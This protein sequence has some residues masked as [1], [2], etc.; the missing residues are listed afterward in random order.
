MVKHDRLSLYELHLNL[1]IGLR[2][3]GAVFTYDYSV[4]CSKEP[5]L[6]IALL[7]GVLKKIRT[8]TASHG[9]QFV[10]V[11]GKSCTVRETHGLVSNLLAD[12]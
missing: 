3:H 6:T 4:T 12:N 9:T 1:L 2:R 5:K 10:I 8:N 11:L 7:Y